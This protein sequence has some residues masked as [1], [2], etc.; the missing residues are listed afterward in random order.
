MK[1]LAMILGLCAF[2]SAPVFADEHTDAAA[3]HKDAATH[4]EPAAAAPAA[5]K[6]KM[7]RGAKHA[8]KGKKAHGAKEH[9]E[10][11]DAPAAE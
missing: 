1:K 7:Q 6:N 4:E 2:I 11:T 5:K 9:T 8:A 3:E 10:H